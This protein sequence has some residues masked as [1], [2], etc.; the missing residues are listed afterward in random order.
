ML[1]IGEPALRQLAALLHQ[2]AGLKVTPDGYYSLK[3][4]LSARMPELGLKDAEAYLRRVMGPSGSQ[5]L[6]RLLPLVTVG[7]T[8]FFRDPKQ[9]RALERRILPDLLSRTRAENRPIRVWS[10]GCATGEEPYSLAIAFK[11]LGAKADELDIWA[12]DLNPVAVENAERGHFSLRRMSTVSLERRRLFF[13]K[14]ELGFQVN[15]SLRESIRF[16]DQNLALDFSGRVSAASFDLILCRNVIIYFDFDTIHRLMDRFLS[17]LRPTALLLLGYSESLFR[18]Y[19]KF[20]MVEIEGAFV[21][22]RPLSSLPLGVPQHRLTSKT[23]LPTPTVLKV[24][25]PPYRLDQAIK[26]IEEGDFDRAGS[27]LETLV[28]SGA[29]NLPAMLTLGNIYSVMGK[30]VK[31]HQIFEEIIQKEPLCVEARLF[32]AVAAL[33]DENLAEAQQQLTKVIFLEVDLGLGHYLMAQVLEKLGDAPGA[34][35]SYRNALLSLNRPQRRLVGH[36][37]DLVDSREFL[38]TAARY[39]LAALEERLG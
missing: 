19:E 4:A 16:E 37:P 31:A 36:Y 21:Y 38:S 14:T 6:R 11:E 17:A 7:H 20:E 32:S 27:L 23:S 28:A 22:R 8:E 29:D 24:E 30:G 10:A 9:F 2:H 18:V 3:I 25:R 26:W 1:I 35:R 13:R 39:A 34:R 33:Q 5:E 15:P 12:T